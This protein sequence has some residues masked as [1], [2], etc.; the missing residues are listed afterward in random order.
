MP[1]THRGRLKSVHDPSI[2]IPATLTFDQHAIQ[3]KSEGETFGDWPLRDFEAERVE[4][5]EFRLV[6]GGETWGF[7]A[8]DP[9]HFMVTSMEIL[10]DRP[11]R[12]RMKQ[13]IR[14]MG[15]AGITVGA[16]SLAVA[17][18][19]TAFAGGVIVG[20]YRLDD[21]VAVVVAAGLVIVVLSLI[22]IRASRSLT[23]PPSVAAREPE[24]R[25]THVTQVVA[26]RHERR[27]TTRSS[28]VVLPSRLG[29]EKPAPRPQLE[30]SRIRPIRPDERSDVGELG[31]AR[32][33]PV[34][35]ELEIP[36]PRPGPET[37]G[38]SGTHSGVPS[39]PTGP[40]GESP[41][42]DGQP[43]AESAGPK[44][45]GEAEAAPISQEGAPRESIQDVDLD[46]ST[47]NGIGPAFAERLRDLGVSD[48]RDLADLDEDGVDIVM[49][50]LGRFGKRIITGDWVG[51][52]R[53]RLDLS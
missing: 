6:I 2:D 24:R 37:T 30:L 28:T 20:R 11:T 27:P 36:F 4:A 32:S 22:R 42:I 50:Y 47:I 48:I 12:G 45:T 26:Q 51:Q 31:Q 8:E 38:A 40:D 17:T 7:M 1:T 18:T 46:L 14:R 52:A 41:V 33:E 43:D 44:K 16:F 19:L 53:R 13:A 25:P 21:N 49:E 10:A 9:A 29:E 5:N 35:G 15:S 39:T 34:D 3:I 23:P